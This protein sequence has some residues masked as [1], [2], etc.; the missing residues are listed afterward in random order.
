MRSVYVS[1]SKGYNF[2]PFPCLYHSIEIYQKKS[3]Y[4]PITLSSAFHS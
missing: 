2:K 1:T 3:P 4:S